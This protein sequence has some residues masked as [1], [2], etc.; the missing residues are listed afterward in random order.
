MFRNKLYL[1][2]A[3]MVVLTLIQAATAVWANQVAAHH[4][5][6]SRVAN[7][8]LA[9]FI[10]L[11]ADKQRLKV[12]LAQALLTNDDAPGVRER[13]LQQMQSHLQ[14]I[15]QLLQQ[16]QQLA[17]TPDDFSAITTQLKTV[18]ILETNVVVLERSLARKASAPSAPL[19]AADTWT[20]L[21]E[22][23][24]NLE[25]LDLKTLIAQAIDLQQQRSA[26]AEAQAAAA[27]TQARLLLFSTCGFAVVLALLMAVVLARAMYRPMQQ[28]L[29]G[30]S[31]LAQ[32]V[33]STRLP[34]QGQQEFVVLA[35]SFNQLAVSLDRARV[36][37][38]AHT[39]QIEKVVAERTA[40]LQDAVSKLQQAERMQQ[41][42]LGD[43]SHE[44]RTPATTIRGEAE[45]ALRGTDK[46]AAEYKESLLR[47]VESSQLLSS[48]IDDLL[49]LVRSDQPLQLRFRDIAV[50]DLWPLWCEQAQRQCAAAQQALVL[51]PASAT[52][53][54][55]H[56][57]IDMDKTMQALQIVLD[58]AIR[59]GQQR[60]LQMGLQVT[61][62]Q[63]QL[64]ITD[65]GIGIP[66]AAQHQL[67]QRYF[68]AE[69]ARNLRP[70]GLGIGLALC[71]TLMQAQHGA[72]QIQSPAMTE[73][74]GHGGTTVV[75]SFPLVGEE[76]EDIT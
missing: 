61:H 19:N 1:A 29:A 43:V 75:L 25:G 66:P 9:G 37:E 15:N 11:G 16:D 44:L 24:D 40:Q 23:F 14:K 28:L 57:F 51:A 26:A 48:R 47:I 42:F 56:L 59:Y 2:F 3:L 71:R 27:L 20:L 5:E 8:M 67:F 30:T 10:S 36:Q 52:M 41:R 39:R 76:P 18:S 68:R 55:Q 74:S 49:L 31:A 12:W 4:V 63:L 33:L 17:Q 45:V 58:N 32:G 38:E 46:S 60:P 22:I 53:L 35:R 62:E 70:D 34:E 54:Q 13:Y 73:P 7:Q 64:S 21:I 50:A 6:R 65:Q 69:N 72:V